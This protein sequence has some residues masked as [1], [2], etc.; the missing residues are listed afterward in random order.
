MPDLISVMIRGRDLIT[1]GDG[2]GSDNAGKRFVTDS[3]GFDSETRPIRSWLDN[4]FD[5][6]ATRIS[7]D[8][9]FLNW[10]R[11]AL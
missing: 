6:T 4:P 7:S 2:N 10:V 5:L 3:I 1:I 11:W 8:A 9:I